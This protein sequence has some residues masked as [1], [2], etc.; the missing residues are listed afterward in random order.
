[1]EEKPIITVKEA[2]KILGKEAVNLTDETILRTIRLLS[3]TAKD[4]L[5]QQLETN[6]SRG[7]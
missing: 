1:M 3:I 7:L 2:R 5:K 6:E 4:L